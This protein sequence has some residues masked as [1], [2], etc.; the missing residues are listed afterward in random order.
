MKFSSSRF[1][2][3]KFLL[4][5]FQNVNFENFFFKIFKISDLKISSTFPKSCFPFQQKNYDDEILLGG[6]K[7]PRLH[8]ESIPLLGKSWPKFSGMCR[9]GLGIQ[10]KWSQLLKPPGKG[11]KSACK[12]VGSIPQ[13]SVVFNCSRSVIVTQ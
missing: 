2:L 5:D 13:P 7:L 3:W 8:G 10:W 12:V 11:P 1:Q 9:I 4:Q 6:Y